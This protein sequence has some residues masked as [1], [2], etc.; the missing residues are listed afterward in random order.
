MKSSTESTPVVKVNGK[1]LYSSFQT[2]RTLPGFIRYALSGLVR[3]GFSVVLLTNR[4]E[5]EPES[6]AFLEQQGVE[7]FFTENLGFDFGMWRRYLDAIPAETRNSWERLLLINDSVVYFR[8]VFGDFLREA[9]SRSADVVSL[10]CN[11]MVAF[12]LQSFFLYMK[13]R[14]IRLFDS[15]LLESP[16]HSEYWDVV[17]SMEIGFSQKVL[18]AGLSLDALFRTER[19]VFFSY[20]DLIKHGSGFVKRRLTE[21]RFTIP[22]ISFYLHNQADYVLK[23]DYVRLIERE[24]H[25]D[26]AFQADWILP[27]SPTSWQK[28]KIA[29]RL[30]CGCAYY[31]LIFKGCAP[32]RH[33]WK[34]S[35]R[36]ALFSDFLVFMIGC[37]MAGWCVFLGGWKAGICGFIA[38]CVVAVLTRRAL[39]ILRGLKPFMKT[40]I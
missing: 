7:L 24:G 17:K 4:R 5:L 28:M 3:T 8:D 22:E 1:I 13:P 2:G 39:Q 33:H 15:H 37:G 40:K 19:N 16:I 21:R 23:T 31:V 35:S 30:V 38:G 11:D 6:L 12:H 18:K 26:P 27:S 10:T 14:A 25:M 32:I 29:L 34:W 36:V 9:E 20:G